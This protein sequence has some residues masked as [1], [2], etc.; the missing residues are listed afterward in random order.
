MLPIIYTKK[1]MYE[2]CG[3]KIYTKKRMYEMCGNKIYTKKR[4]YEMCGNKILSQSPSIAC[5]VY[6]VG[7]ETKS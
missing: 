4:M 6:K 1:R 2:M 7:F 5:S 3:N